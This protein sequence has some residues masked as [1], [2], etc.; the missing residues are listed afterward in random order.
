MLEPDDKPRQIPEKFRASLDPN[1][2]AGFELL[3]RNDEE[4]KALGERINSP[5]MGNSPRDVLRSKAFI[6]I[7][8]L[9]NPALTLTDEQKESLSEAFATVGRFD[10][11]SETS[12]IN[13]DLYE[14]YWFAIR[15][16]PL[17]AGCMHEGHQ[18]IKDW[19]WSIADG[20]DVPVTVCT[21]PDCDAAVVIDETHPLYKADQAQQALSGATKGMTIE[22]A[23]AF[24]IQHVKKG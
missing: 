15:L 3:Q 7:E 4:Q 20:K 13:K 21:V 9:T 2:P 23:K 5:F 10:L 8:A 18:Y 17:S 16:G 11:A 19:V 1:D 22:Q 12:I 24:H 6:R 14:R